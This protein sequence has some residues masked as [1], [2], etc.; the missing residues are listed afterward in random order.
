M[1][2]NRK[3]LVEVCLILSLII[4]PL[5]FTN[6]YTN[7]IATKYISFMI[8]AIVMFYSY[9]ITTVYNNIDF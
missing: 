1:K 3:N 7:L 5:I 8:I 6:L 4:Y 9:T 2:S